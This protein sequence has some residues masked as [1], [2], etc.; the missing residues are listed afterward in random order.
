MM[1]KQH[2]SSA[3]IRMI[4][5]CVLSV[6]ILSPI[7]MIV[8]IASEDTGDLFSHLFDTVLMRYIVNTLLLMVGA[9]AI[10]VL[11]GVSAAWVVCR[12]QFWG[13]GVFELLLVLPAAMPAYLVAYAYTDFLEYSGPVQTTLRAI[14][15]WKTAQDYA[16]FEI[17]SLSGAAVM[18]GLVLYPY[19]YLMV[20]TALRQTSSSFF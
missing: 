15:G 18:M 2:F 20:R 9:G 16:F 19:V 6:I 11:F 17:R 5:L 13:R 12:Y 10:A 8:M 3:H 14:F 4:L 1:P 7:V